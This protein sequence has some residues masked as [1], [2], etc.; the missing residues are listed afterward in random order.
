[1]FRV[2]LLTATVVFLAVDAAGSA[3][4]A[5]RI[6]VW[7]VGI[8]T[9]SLDSAIA[10]CAADSEAKGFVVDADGPRPRLV[11]CVDDV[12]EAAAGCAYVDPHFHAYTPAGVVVDDGET[13]Y[14]PCDRVPEL[15]AKSP[16]PP[17]PPTS[18][19]TVVPPNVCYIDGK[20]HSEGRRH[21]GQVCKCYR[22]E[23]FRCLWE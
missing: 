4:A 1:M 5:G 11:V 3:E 9:E 22:E 18:V 2:H 10:E 14:V 7:S 21:D 12:S 13:G 16:P 23:S 20:A 6:H 8:G 19:D 15:L 17:A